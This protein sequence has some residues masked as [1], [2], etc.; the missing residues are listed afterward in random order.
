ME[1]RGIQKLD[2]YGNL[3]LI[4]EYLARAIMAFILVLTSG[5]WAWINIYLDICRFIYPKKRASLHIRRPG[6]SF[7]LQ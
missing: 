2:K 6:Q 3:A 7:P 5:T 4:R 1:N